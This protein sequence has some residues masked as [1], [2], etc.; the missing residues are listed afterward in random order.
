MERQSK[1]GKSD[2]SICEH[3]PIYAAQRKEEGQQPQ[4]AQ[5]GRSSKK[6]STQPDPLY[7]GMGIIHARSGAG[8]AGFD[9]YI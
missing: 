8:A 7:A 4:K 9:M 5:A 6:Q 2:P 3:A 1:V